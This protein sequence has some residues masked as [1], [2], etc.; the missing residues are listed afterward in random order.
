[1]EVGGKWAKRNRGLPSTDWTH[2][3]LTSKVLKQEKWSR[4]GDH[5][6]TEKL[7]KLDKA[8][9]REGMNSWLAGR[10]AG[11]A[12]EEIPVWC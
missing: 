2:R 6:V 4:R 11:R 12:E 1:M 7:V 5:G 8:Q 9:L 3:I 10:L